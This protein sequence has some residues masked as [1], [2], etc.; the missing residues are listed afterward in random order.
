MILL[1]DSVHATLP[2]LASG[3][4]MAFEDGAVLGYCLSDITKN[5]LLKDRIKALRL[6]EKCR[7]E[8]TYRIVDRGTLQMDLNHLSDGPEQIARDDKMRAFAEIEKQYLDGETIEWTTLHKGDDPL[9]WRR[10]G[11]GEWLLSYDPKAD[12]EW[13]REMM[14]NGA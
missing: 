5:T 11:A 3:A 10:Y 12:V 13:H 4:G 8:R 6:Y 9:V 14:V 1:G 2:Y 7:V